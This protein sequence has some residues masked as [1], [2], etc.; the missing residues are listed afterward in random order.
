M[1]ILRSLVQAGPVPAGTDVDLIDDES[2]AVASLSTNANGLTTVNN[3]TVGDTYSV[4]TSNDSGTAAEITFVAT[5]GQTVNIPFDSAV[6]NVLPTT[7]N[8][9]PTK[10]TTEPDPTA[11]IPSIT[12][13]YALDGNASQGSGNQWNPF[14]IYLDKANASQSYNDSK[15]KEDGSSQMSYDYKADFSWT[16]SDTYNSTAG[17]Y[18]DSYTFKSSDGTPTSLFSSSTP[19]CPSGET[20]SPPYTLQIYPFSA[21]PGGCTISGNTVAQWKLT[22]PNYATST[23]FSTS[24]WQPA[25]APYY[26]WNNYYYWNYYYYPYALYPYYYGAYWNYGFYWDYWDY[27]YYYGNYWNGYYG[28]NWNGYY[29]YYNGTYWYNYY[30]YNMFLNGKAKGTDSS[31]DTS[32]ISSSQ[33]YNLHLGGT[34]G[35]KYNV[36]IDF[37]IY[38]INI[39]NGFVENPASGPLSCNQV[40]LNG[41]IATSSSPSIPSSQGSCAVILTESGGSGGDTITPSP[42][43]AQNP[44]ISSLY[45]VAWGPMTVTKPNLVIFVGGLTNEDDQIDPTN[46]SSYWGAFADLKNNLQVQPNEPG[47]AIQTIINSSPASVLDTSD[48]D[49]DFTQ[50]HY[51]S[52]S[53]SINSNANGLNAFIRDIPNYD[54]YQHVYIITHSLGQTVTRA[55][56]DAAA[57]KGF[58]C[59]SATGD[60]ASLAPDLTSFYS[61]ADV[62]S[63]SPILGG[64]VIPGVR[65][66]AYPPAV[67]TIFVPSLK[68]W[69]D[70]D[71]DGAYETCLY[72]QQNAQTF[73]SALSYKYYTY[74]ISGDPFLNGLGAIAE[75]DYHLWPVWEYLRV[76]KGETCSVNPSSLIN[77]VFSLFDGTWA[78][79]YENGKAPNHISYY[80]YCNINGENGSLLF[81]TKFARGLTLTTADPHMALLEYKPL[82]S[83]IHKVVLG[84]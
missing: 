48:P 51:P 46:P 72:D 79:D 13:A 54:Q 1:L 3:A 76:H 67:V 8:P 69:R 35:V 17:N 24:T 22:E 40:E 21:E 82:W 12:Y 53:Q 66:Q 23:M 43:Y 63:I 70:I 29:G 37:S 32:N 83:I 6:L 33:T 65:L 64:S 47:P 10:P 61:N 75:G 84:Y 2:G 36:K 81:P 41:I 15:Y 20:Y 16:G 28:D 44:N 11:G 7:Q 49:T 4:V 62:I 34:S 74:I 39:N 25:V 80:Y 31:G 38:P 78:Q 57:S 42:N 14:Y 73:T 26:F 59:P 52:E 68:I 71:P 45:A 9:L 27:D 58:S 19:P 56:V 5:A 30:Y 77:G 60:T 18:S 50:Y 55:A